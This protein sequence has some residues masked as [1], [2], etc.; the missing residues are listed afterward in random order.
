MRAVALIAGKEVRDG[1]RNR[2]VVAIAAL[3]AIFALTLGFL[4]AAP[5]GVVKVS[6]LAVTI[7]SLSSLSIFLLPLIGLLLSYD[8]IVGEWDR[9]T[10]ALLLAYP[11]ARWQVILGKFAGHVCIL[12]IATVAGYGAAGAALAMTSDASADA[13]TAFTVM[14]G[15]S[16]LLGAVF[17]A[18]GYVISTLVR[19]RAAAGGIAIGVWLLL[20]IVYDMAMLGV[21]VADQGRT[22]D[23]AAVNWMLLI[24]PADAYRLLN[25][26]GTNSVSGFAGV[27]GLSAQAGLS[28]AAAIGSL[29][30]WTI[31]P[32]AVATALFA[33]R[34]I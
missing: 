34:Q 25:L 2:W 8:T 30:L 18:I 26:A 23:S 3:L 15:S 28:S 17:V 9:G 33:W 16:I 13:W 12:A 31:V 27:A 32:L 4:G 14:T 21:L 24:N 10:L 11:V 20:V 6:P 5:T 29:A 1:L 22:L 19:D 7:V